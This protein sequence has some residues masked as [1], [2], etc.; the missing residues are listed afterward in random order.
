MYV[1]YVPVK[2]AKSLISAATSLFDTTNDEEEDVVEV[3]VD[4]VVVAL[5]FC[6]I[7]A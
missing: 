2:I 7:F 6:S 5:T 3:S 4:N 1:S